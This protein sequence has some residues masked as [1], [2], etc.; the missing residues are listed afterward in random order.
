M[1]DAAGLQAWLESI[2]R[3]GAGRSDAILFA[4]SHRAVLA[5]DWSALTETAELALALQPSAER[6]LEA[7]AQ[8]RAFLAAVE[9][10]WPSPI[11]D[12]FKQA[13]PD[14]TAYPVAVG[15]ASA[16]HGLPLAPA[17]RAALHGVAANLVSAGVRLI[18]LGQTDGLKVLAGLESA[19]ERSAREAQAASLDE[20]GGA[21]LLADI[22]SMRHETQYTR[23]FRT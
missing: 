2:I 22:A 3:H 9:A 11:I 7:T 19:I 13:W 12:R 16:A 4:A 18:P 20:V 17:L 23:L 10:V 14:D 5:G 21:T 6:R 1:R 8:G 15:V